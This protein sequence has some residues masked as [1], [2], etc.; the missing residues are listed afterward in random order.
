[1]PIN[2]V[3]V[4]MSCSKKKDRRDAC[5]YQNE[6]RIIYA[7]L[8]RNLLPARRV[9]PVIKR[10]VLTGSGTIATSTLILV[11]FKPVCEIEAFVVSE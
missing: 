9:P 4:T 3:R 7:F 8:L 11:V 1:M 5:P 2:I 10:I 6:M